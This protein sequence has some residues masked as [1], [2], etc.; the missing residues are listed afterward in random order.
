MIKSGYQ[1]GK[2]NTIL[3]SRMTKISLLQE[4]S[5]FNSV[6]YLHILY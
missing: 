1:C 3:E 4:Y 2:L 6:G 5:N